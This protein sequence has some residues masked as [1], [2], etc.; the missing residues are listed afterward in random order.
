[1]APRLV[2]LRAAVLYSFAALLPVALCHVEMKVPAPLRSKY[3]PDNVY[4]TIDY[5]MNSPLQPDGSDFP[6]KGYQNDRPV[7][8]TAQYSVGSS[9]KITLEGSSTHA[10]GSCQLSLSYDN[11]AT[12]RVIKSMIGG[13]PLDK[14]YNFTVPLF[15]PTG[16]ALISWTWQNKIGNREFFMNCAA[17]EIFPEA[18]SRR[19]R[20]SEAY[21]SF[22]ELPFMWRANLATV[23][24]CVTEENRN[25]VYPHPGPEVEY[26]DG[27]SSLDAISPGEC[28]SSLPRGR[29]YSAAS[30]GD[31]STGFYY[32]PSPSGQCTE[33]C[34][35][36]VATKC[37]PRD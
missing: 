15:A 2:P 31:A 25:P 22:D 21:R 4:G 9:Y 1:M 5:D 10:G 35:C 32:E 19:R 18:R 6:C 8:P 36:S 29:A 3:N 33:D 27:M 7:V 13:C 23:E 12:F 14:Q 20:S 30:N 37:N 24:G 26:G 11:G 16:P 34:E 28:D 17:V